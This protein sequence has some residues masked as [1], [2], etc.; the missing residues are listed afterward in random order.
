MYVK[1]T[2]PNGKD[3]YHEVTGSKS[4]TLSFDMETA[5]N[6]VAILCMLLI[7]MGGV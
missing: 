1:A 4:R 5:D 6:E 3:L 2:L 7:I